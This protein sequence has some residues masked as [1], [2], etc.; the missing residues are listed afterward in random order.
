LRSP[1]SHPQIVRG[2]NVASIKLEKVAKIFPDGT[3]AV[4]NLDL[5]IGDGEYV[6]LV[7]PSGCGKTTILRIIAGLEQPTRGRVY[8]DDQDVTDQPPQKRDVAM[9]FQSHAL[10]PH[11]TVRDNLGFG[12]RLRRA[13]RKLVVERVE[14]V[15][16]SLKLSPLLDRKPGQLSGGERQRVALGRAMAR[17]PRAFLLDEPLSNLDAQLRIQMRGELTRIRREMA[18][19]TVYVTHDQEEAM[20]LGDRVAVL[21]SGKLQQFDRPSE[22]YRRPVNL[23]VAGFIGTPAMNFFRARF[24][25]EDGNAYLDAPWLKRKLDVT[26]HVQHEQNIVMGIRPHDIRLADSENADA[27][28]L[29]EAVNPL[30][31]EVAVQASLVGKTDGGMVSILLPGDFSAE[32]H[33]PISL[34]FARENIHIFD[35]VNERRLN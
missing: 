10:Y 3:E 13:A 9:V 34:A 7:G 5:E 15:A 31:R 29:V 11:R 8:L 12:L 22:I 2:K 14:Q 21:R 4:H 28:A 24:H 26:L 16:N 33:Q 30:G 20:V 25:T 23:F 19:T 6:A 32:R 17:R 18:T 1:A 27:H 35:P